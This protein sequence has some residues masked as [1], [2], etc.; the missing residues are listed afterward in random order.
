MDDNRSI[1]KID[2]KRSRWPI[3]LSGTLVAVG[4]YLLASETAKDETILNLPLNRLGGFVIVAGL[5]IF[6]SW[7]LATF[8]SSLIFVLRNYELFPKIFKPGRMQQELDDEAERI[9]KD[10]SKLRDLAQEHE[11]EKTNS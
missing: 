7:F 9:N 6:V 8:A 5:L 1:Q 4:I 3:Y 2:Y 11:V 10:I